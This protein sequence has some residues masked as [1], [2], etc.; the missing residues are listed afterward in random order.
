[1]HHTVIKRIYTLTLSHTY[2]HRIAHTDVNKHTY[3]HT[4]THTYTHV[5]SYR[6]HN[7]HIELDRLG[8]HGMLG[9]EPLECWGGHVSH[10]GVF[11]G[12]GY[13]GG[14]GMHCRQDKSRG[15]GRVKVGW[16]QGTRRG[17]IG[18]QWVQGSRG[19]L[20]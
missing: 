6:Q 11:E 3:A 5:H 18:W 9:P 16:V 7:S 1:M 10:P 17:R 8:L 14:S 12:G 2:I 15:V 13:T 19:I 4:H 20:G